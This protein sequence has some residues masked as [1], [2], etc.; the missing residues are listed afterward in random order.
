MIAGEGLIFLVPALARA[1]SGGPPPPH[2]AEARATNPPLTPAFR[3]LPLTYR[4][5]GAE[6]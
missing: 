6:R 1:R 3:L 2:R 4:L 5:R